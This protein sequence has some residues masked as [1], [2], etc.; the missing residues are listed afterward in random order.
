[1]EDIAAKCDTLTEGGQRQH[2]GQ[3]V[4]NVAGGGWGVNQKIFR[5]YNKKQIA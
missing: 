1:M 5:V 4:G 2:C 3:F